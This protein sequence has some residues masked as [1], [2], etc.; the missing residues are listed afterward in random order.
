MIG[1]IVFPEPHHTAAAEAIFDLLKDRIGDKRRAITIAGESGAGKSE[2]ALE[3]DRLFAAT[4]KRSL[5]LQQDDYFF[6]PPKSNEENRRKNIK[7]VGLG[8][9]NLVLMN[10]HVRRFKFSPGEKL[11]KPLVI[12]EENRIDKETL[13]PAEF[14]ILI[15]EGTYTTLLKHA[16]YHVFIDKTYE[17]TLAHRQ[18][19]GRD[20]LDEAAERFLEI[21]HSIISKHR[22]LAE[23]VVNGDYTVTWVEK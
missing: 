6:L 22:T 21:E 12:F 7:S 19:R 14:D 20:P 1:D 5:I 15:A 23:I 8:E 3:I 13:V 4:G 17:E 11:E 18:G 9:V 10:E 2:I 16:D